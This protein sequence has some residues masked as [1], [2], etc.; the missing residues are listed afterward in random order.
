[1]PDLL[2]PL[3][4]ERDRWFL[5]LPVAM[6]LGVE[7]YFG[8]PRE[9][10]LAA[11]FL[12]AGVGLLAAWRLR[13][14]AVLYPV[15]L[16]ALAGLG[17]GMAALET[18]LMTQPMLREKTAATNVVGRVMTINP[19]PDGY[20]VWLSG[21]QVEDLPEK[22][23]P[24]TVR[25]KI[26][27]REEVPEPGRWI[28]VRA[29][30]Y[31]LSRPAEPGAFDFRRYAFYQGYGATGFSIG[32]WRYGE[33]PPADMAGRLAIAF[34]KIRAGIAQAFFAQGKSREA[35]VAV[36]L[37]TGDQAG[38]DKGTMEAMRISGIS[39]IL[40]VSGLHITLVAGIVFFTLRALLALIP[41]AALHW[42]IK[43][44]AAFAALLAAVF[45]TLMCAAPVPAVRAML[46]SSLIL[47]AV[48]ADRRTLS[49]RLVAFAALASLLVAPSAM[50]DPSFQ[51]SF[52]AVAALVAVFEK[53]E[54]ALWRR[55][56]TDGWLMRLTLYIGFTVLTSLVAA[57]ATAP[58][59][60][61]HFQQVNWYGVFT[62][63]VAVPLSTF[64]IMPAAILAVLLIPFGLE[65]LPLAL[66]REAIGWMIACAQWVSGLPG[67]VTYHPAMAPVF[68]LLVAAGGLWLCLWRESWRFIGLV[69]FLLGTF[70]FLFAERP[71][72]FVA[73]DGITLAL[74]AQ[75]GRLIARAKDR[76]AFALK[77]WQQRDGRAGDGPSYFLD[78]LDLAE[79]G[80]AGKL[81]CTDYD[82]S[83]GGFAFPMR[84]KGL[85]DACGAYEVVVAPAAPM[86]C[87]TLYTINAQHVAAAGSH[88]FYMK[89][90]K[91][92]LKTA[93]Q[94]GHERPWH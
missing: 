25:L 70:G 33:G 19:L 81:H 86:G 4:H 37:V 39:H 66:M 2:S 18:R 76:E 93:R 45:Y 53:N 88:A 94:P 56:Y 79:Q 52:G 38:I 77:V 46:M 55:F 36:A 12:V 20:R 22:D 64:I 27:Y 75:D 74:R 62:N 8:W 83:T 13:G 42:P 34:E 17:F 49:M 84:A 6:G 44:I 29:I 11:G 63:L 31:P 68:I 48:M 23:T 91:P 26:R 14:H 92:V 21:V 15:L 1:M 78:W 47:I 87:G 43:K 67:A 41:G 7:L 72:L 69:P 32:K 50:L 60:L 85:D 5:W 24:R 9:P 10:P 61:Y 35:A 65:S 90:A 30:L 59:I 73:D 89:D 82:F 71:H 57:V 58:F 28:G 16:V 54:H 3:L 80:G 51:L 40:S